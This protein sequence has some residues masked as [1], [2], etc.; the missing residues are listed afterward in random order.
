MNDFQLESDESYNDNAFNDY[1]DK[2]EDKPSLATDKEPSKASG[3]IS[4]Y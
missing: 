1:E 3:S 2:V 4:D